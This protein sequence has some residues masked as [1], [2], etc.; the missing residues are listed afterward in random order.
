M[1]DHHNHRLRLCAAYLTGVMQGEADGTSTTCMFS[2]APSTLAA[3]AGAGTNVVS[4]EAAAAFV[5]SAIG[6]AGS[7]SSVARVMQ[8]VTLGAGKSESVETVHGSTGSITQGKEQLGAAECG[9]DGLGR[10]SSGGDGD[11][12]SSEEGG[13]EGPQ[14]APSAATSNSSNSEC[15]GFCAE[16]KHGRWHAGLY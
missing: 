7:R 12:H 11:S 10:A 1:G 14:P 4:N 15:L 6:H 16:R 13:Q 2:N 9:L 3:C 8:S 5:E